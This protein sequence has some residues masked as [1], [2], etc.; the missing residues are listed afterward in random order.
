MSTRR[1]PLIVLSE[2]GGNDLGVEISL[3]KQRFCHHPACM[4]NFLNPLRIEYSLDYKQIFKLLKVTFPFLVMWI[5]ETEYILFLTE[6]QSEFDF[7]LQLCGKNSYT[8]VKL[9]E[10]LMQRNN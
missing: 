6:S 8:C 5:G 2:T 4:I 10:C 1:V 7:V 3:R 9:N